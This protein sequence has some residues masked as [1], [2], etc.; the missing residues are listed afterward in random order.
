MLIRVEGMGDTGSF[1]P[2]ASV[3]QCGPEL[4]ARQI[5]DGTGAD[6]GEDAQPQQIAEV[7]GVQG[8]KNVARTRTDE[9]KRPVRR[10]GAA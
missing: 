6:P 8:A 2:T 10:G 4:T 1:A 5:S 9:P 7:M 3:S